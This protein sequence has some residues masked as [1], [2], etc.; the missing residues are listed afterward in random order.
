MFRQDVSILVGVTILCLL[1]MS[2]GTNYQYQIKFLDVPLDHFSYVNDSLTFKLRYLINDTYDPTGSGPILFYTGNEGD[3]ELFAQNTGFMWEIAPK[4]KA[5][6]VFA[7]HRFYGK[8]LPFGNASYES[9]K[10]LGYLSSEQA[11]ADFAHLL[12]EINPIVPGRRNRPV[13]AFGGS[14]GGMLAAWIRMKYPHLVNGA[15]AASAPIRQFYTDCGIFNQILTTVF[16]TAYKEE[17]ASNIARSWDALR[18]YSSTAEGLKTLQDKFKFCNNVTKAE[19]ITGTFFD[20]MNDVYGNL[21]MIN[22]PY[23]STFLAPV[24]A[25]P[26]REFCGRL[27]QNYT[28]LELINHLQDAL[29]IYTNYTGTTKCLNIASAY[30]SKMG[31]Q[32]WNFQSCTE[33]YMPMCAKGPGKDMFPKQ[34]WDD[35]KYSDNCFKQ[36]GV[37]PRNKAALAIY[38]GQYLDDASNIVFSNGLMDPWSGGGVLRSNNPS[39]TVILIPEGAHHIDLRAANEKDPGSVIASRQIHLQNIQKWIKQHSKRRV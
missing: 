12:T 26:V 15:I 19:D 16:K 1:G 4:L 18:N 34:P 23:N 17:C 8:T 11:L 24:P 25:Y 22:Y 28:G 30:D 5:S 31:D 21:A 10:H 6:L 13:I 37:R 14:Y 36:F 29:S 35:K 20:Y 32:G 3:I 7:E 38:G 33:M 39:I 2:T 9:P 27:A